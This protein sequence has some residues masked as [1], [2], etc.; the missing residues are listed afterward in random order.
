M[1]CMCAVLDSSLVKTTQKPDLS[2][3]LNKKCSKIAKTALK[4]PNFWRLRRR[5]GGL[6]LRSHATQILLDSVPKAEQ[7]KKE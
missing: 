7:Q 5:G 2:P 4:L 1:L 6:G 3:I